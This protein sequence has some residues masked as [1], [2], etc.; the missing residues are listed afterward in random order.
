MKVRKGKLALTQPPREWFS[1]AV[2]AHGLNE[3]P[4]SSSIAAYACEVPLAHGDPA[5]RMI[6]ATAMLAGMSAVTS[7]HL[8]CACPGL[9]VVW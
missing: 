7:D 6:V 8:I 5:D 1:R 2:L 4:I 3:A 9:S